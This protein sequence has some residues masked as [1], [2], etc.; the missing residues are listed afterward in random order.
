MGVHATC[1]VI[2]MAGV[3]QEISTRFLCGLRG[4]HEYCH[5]WTPVQNE[6]LC[7][8]QE[9]RNPH[10]YYAIAAIKQQQVV[11]HLPKEISRFTWFIINRGAAV[12]VK[13][14]DINY[15]RSPLVQ[16]G[17]EI[18]IEVC[19]VMPLSDANKRALDK[20]RTLVTENY[21]EPV[22]GNFSDATATV[23]AHLYASSESET[24]DEEEQ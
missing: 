8:Q 17:L 4:Y 15:R 23:L 14:V 16:G 18:P 1:H 6:V 7:V 12:S 21:E 13:V 5:E 19:V 9:R 20:Y 11:G 22:N 3:S 10:D 24:D 2:Y